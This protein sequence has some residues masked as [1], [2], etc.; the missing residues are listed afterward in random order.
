M[1]EVHSNP[2]PGRRPASH[3]IGEDVIYGEKFGRLGIF[4]LPPLQTPKRSLLVWRVR[5]DHKRH[6]RPR[7]LRRGPGP[8]RGHAWGFALH[9]AKV[10][11]PGRVAEAGG[12]ITCREL[13]QL[14]ERTRRGI[15]PRVWIADFGE[16]FRNRKYREVGRL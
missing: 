16:A 11:G 9:L 13:E 10:G 6:P 15:H 12:L 14:F 2:G 1:P 3:G 7:L 8:R 4:A 5:D